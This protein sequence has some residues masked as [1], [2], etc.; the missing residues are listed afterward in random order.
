MWATME[1][2]TLVLT[3]DLNLDRLRPEH[4]EGQILLNLEEVYGLECLNKDP[5]RVT[6]TSATLLDF[7]LTNKPDV[8][9]A[10]G[11]MNPEISDHYLVYRIMKV[12]MSQHQRKRV[13]FRSTKSLD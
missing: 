8:F 3:G 2:N 4:K 13:T 9:I 10:S 5:T 12:R 1:C 11:V 6:P 7:I